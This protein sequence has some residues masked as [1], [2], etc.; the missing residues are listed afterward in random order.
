MSFDASLVNNTVFVATNTAAV[1]AVNNLGGGNYSVDST[2]YS[3]SFYDYWGPFPSGN[4]AT[5]TTNAYNPALAPGVITFSYTYANGTVIPP[6][7][8]VVIGWNAHD[9]LV[10]VLAGFVP[11][12]Q[13]AGTYVGTLSTSDYLIL[14]GWG[15]NL[16]FEANDGAG[17]TLPLTFGN[18][19]SFTVP[20]PS[21]Y[22]L[23]LVA[24]VATTIIRLP[25]VRRLLGGRTA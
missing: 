8:G 23:V 20:E 13:S 1:N 2:E 12:S 14:G 6:F 4:V 10:D 24:L 15:Q 21:T 3:G 18:T 5:T 17:P 22:A 25:S 11:I 9:I 7:G 16:S 19:G